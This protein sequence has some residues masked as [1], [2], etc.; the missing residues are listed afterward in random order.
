ML[1]RVLEEEGNQSSDILAFAV[2]YHSLDCSHTDSSRD[3]LALSLLST[4]E[5]I[6]NVICAQNGYRRS[7]HGAYT[8]Q[9]ARS[10]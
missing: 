1:R 9:Q 8:L 7:R 3:L 6:E 10:E 2:T 5:D 4:L